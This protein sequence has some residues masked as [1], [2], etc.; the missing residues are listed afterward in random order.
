LPRN[1]INLTWS[2]VRTS[3]STI[4]SFLSEHSVEDA[5]LGLYGLLKFALNLEDWR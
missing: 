2:S 5:C 1:L 3:I 4:R